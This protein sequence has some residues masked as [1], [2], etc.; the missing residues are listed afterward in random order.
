MTSDGPADPAPLTTPAR[1]KYG[2]QVMADRRQRILAQAQAMLDELGVEGFTIRELSSRA[3]VAQRTL[4]NLFGSKEDIVASAIHDHF[5]GLLAELPPP[6]QAVDLEGHLQ[7][8]DALLDR[9]IALK[10]YATAMVGVFFSPSVDRRLYD[11]LRWISEGG[12]AAWVAQAVRDGV[13]V[14][15]T[16]EDRER[17]STLLVNT[18]YAN[19]TDWA[20]GRISADELKTRFKMNF[21]NCIQPLSRPPHRTAIATLLEHVRRGEVI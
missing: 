17:L 10:R 1:R 21:L 6:P 18:G 11:T 8:I 3:D 19:I 2:S 7:R 14:K 9:T 20:A 15:L 5:A 16:P 12:S 4:Y 13:L